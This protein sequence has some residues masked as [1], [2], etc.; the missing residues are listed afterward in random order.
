MGQYLHKV[1][2]VNPELPIVKVDVDD[3]NGREIADEFEVV[4]LPTVLFV[5]KGQI[6]H[7]VMGMDM[8]GMVNGLKMFQK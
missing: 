7:K 6:L 8:E 3:E 5:R 4:S 1:Q 2:E